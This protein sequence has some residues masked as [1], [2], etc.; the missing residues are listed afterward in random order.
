LPKIFGH[1]LSRV[2]YAGMQSRQDA[3]RAL[4]LGVRPEAVDVCGNMKFDSAPGLPSPEIVE[5]LRAELGIDGG[6]P[7][8][9]GGSTHEGEEAALL[10]VYKKLLS[11]FPGIRLVIAPRHLER[12][13]GVAAK[14]KAEGFSILRR[15]GGADQTRTSGE[16][17]ILLDTVGELANVYALASIAFVG[18][19]LAKI[20]GHNI[21][22]PA[23][24]G[25]PVLFGPHMHHFKAVKEAFLSEQA[26][27]CV[28]GEEDLHNAITELLSDPARADVLGEAASRV[29]EANRGATDRYYQAIRKYF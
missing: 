5:S 10:Q 11:R 3:D 20:G 17:V 1:V 26:A 14:I 15:S 18:G 28:S 29:V 4:Q 2:S 16:S 8:I 21:I 22:E 23:S 25:K 9:V 24:M 27:V 6:V 7:V 13:D 12:F 19:S